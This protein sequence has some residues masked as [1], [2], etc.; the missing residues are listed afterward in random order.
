MKHV[1]FIIIVILVFSACTP[2]DTSTPKVIPT[3]T[4]LKTATPTAANSPSPTMTP[5]QIWNGYNYFSKI[6]AMVDFEGLKCADLLWEDVGLE[7]KTGSVQPFAIRGLH[8][9]PDAEVLCS[10]F[11]VVPPIPGE[12]YIVYNDLSKGIQILKVTYSQSDINQNVVESLKN[13]TPTPSQ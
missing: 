2:S 7:V 13:T 4:P 10:G 8:A 9:Q 12:G 1:V 3:R 11:F 6:Q 5:T